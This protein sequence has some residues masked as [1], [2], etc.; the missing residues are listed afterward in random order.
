MLGV[1]AQ[2]KCDNGSNIKSAWGE[3]DG[4]TCAD[5]NLQLCVV[6]TTEIPRIQ[7][8]LKR[9]AGITAHFSRSNLGLSKLHEIQE[10][11]GLPKTKPASKAATRWNGYFVQGVWFVQNADAILEYDE[12][13][14]LIADAVC[15]PLSASTAEHAGP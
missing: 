15:T 14:T 8:V 9:M 2:Q 3:L 1:H 7:Q 12:K 6:K 13:V 11:R 10:K 4:E 5:H